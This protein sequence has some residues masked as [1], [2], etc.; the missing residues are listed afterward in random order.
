MPDPKYSPAFLLA[1]AFVLPHEEEFARG[2]WGD[3]NFVVTE[4][5]AGDSGGLTKYGID[6]RSHPGVDI[7]GLTRPGAIG[8]YHD[9]WKWRNL[10]A[11]PAKLAVALFDVWVNGGYPVKWLQRAIN[12]TNLL[13]RVPSLVVDGDLGPKTIAAA[14][15]CDQA[16]ILRYF[17][18]ER[19]S[20]FAL[21]AANIP[22]DRQFFKGWKQRD[23]DLTA[24]L[25]AA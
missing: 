24:Y 17:I 11:L 6:Q 25:L 2:H 3:E 5:V 9:E 12:A 23:I 16:A 8:I 13:K 4:N 20:R 7:A 15:A 14:Q 10:D 19:D 1:I 22:K 21:L 18:N